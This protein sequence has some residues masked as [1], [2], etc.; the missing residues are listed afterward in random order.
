[1][2]DKLNLYKSLAAFFRAGTA[3]HKLYRLHAEK[4]FGKKWDN[5]QRNRAWY[6]DLWNAMQ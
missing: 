1:M 2:N 4:A 5:G 6:D 3:G